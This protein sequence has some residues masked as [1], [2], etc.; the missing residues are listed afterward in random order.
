MCLLVPEISL[1][2]T[3]FD[4]KMYVYIYYLWKSLIPADHE[5]FHFSHIFKAFLK[6]IVMLDMHWS[7]PYKLS[8]TSI[9]IIFWFNVA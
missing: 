5:H 8:M 4:V 9:E 1:E 2:N 3:S 7:F 6:N